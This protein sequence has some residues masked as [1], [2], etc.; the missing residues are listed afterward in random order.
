MTKAKSVLKKLRPVLKKSGWV[1]G[2]ER[3]VK[4]F[5]FKDFDDAF[6]F[7]TRCALAIAKLDHHPEWLNVY[8]KVHVE[9]TTHDAGGVTEKDCELAAL[10]D[11]IAAL[12]PKKAK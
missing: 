11:K 1:Y 8:N 12:F 7:M 10:M 5:V 4:T 3:I 9:L 6:G 2:D